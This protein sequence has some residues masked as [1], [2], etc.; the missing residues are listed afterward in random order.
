MNCSF[1]YEGT[2]Y[3]MITSNPTNNATNVYEVVQ[4]NSQHVLYNDDLDWYI[5]C[6]DNFGNVGTSSTYS[7]DTRPD[8]TDN[9]AGGGGGAV[10]GTTEQFTTLNPK[11]FTLA[12]PSEWPKGDAIILTLKVY[13]NSEGIYIPQKVEFDFDSNNFAMISKVEGDDNEIK[14]IFKVLDSAKVGDATITI[15]VFDEREVSQNAVFRITEGGIHISAKDTFR[16]YIPWFLGGLGVIF[17]LI[18]L[19]AAFAGRKP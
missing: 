6:T 18:V 13:N 10:G 9:N 2:L 16:K 1:Y 19:I 17:V 11:Y 3:S 8:L 7:L 5:T 14:T 12:Y 15:K 4:I